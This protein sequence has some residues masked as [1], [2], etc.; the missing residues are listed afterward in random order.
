LQARDCSLARLC[1]AY[2]AAR[3]ET[4]LQARRPR[5][6]SERPRAQSTRLGA[7]RGPGST[8]AGACR[9]ASAR[10]L[11]HDS[12]ELRRWRPAESALAFVLVRAR[13]LIVCSPNSWLLSRLAAQL[14]DA[15]SLLLNRRAAAVLVSRRAAASS[16]R[17]RA[18]ARLRSV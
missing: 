3:I 15:Q 18:E 1:A 9:A 5:A 2:R 11:Q 6:L 7:P 4:H 8:S 16:G 17:V 10:R 12:A 13:F 14:R